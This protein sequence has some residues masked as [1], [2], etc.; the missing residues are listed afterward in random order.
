[1][2]PTASQGDLRHVALEEPCGEVRPFADAPLSDSQRVGVLLQLAAVDALLAGCVPLDRLG[3]DESGILRSRRSSGD[4]R[5]TAQER[6]ARAVGL[7]F[8]SERRIEGRGAAR[9]AVRLLQKRW[10]QSLVAIAPDRLVADVLEAAPFLWTARH[11]EAR[12][13]LVLASGREVRVAG[14]GALRDWILEGC[15]D[16]EAVLER[17]SELRRGSPPSTPRSDPAERAAE[18]FAAGRYSECEALLSGRR[19][20]SAVLGFLCAVE[21]GRLHSARR[22]L[23]VAYRHVSPGSREF[24]RLCRGAVRLYA[25]L[26]QSKKLRRWM[27][28]SL[29]QERRCGGG[30]GRVVAAQGYWDLGRLDAMARHLEACS[31]VDWN[32]GLTEREQ[33]RA[34]LHLSLGDGERAVRALGRALGAERRRLSK[35][36]AGRLWNDMISA[37]VLQGDLGGAE[38]AARHA[39]RLL[40]AGEGPA[41]QTLALHN[42]AEVRLRR[43]FGEGVEA[44]LDEVEE[45]NR[46]SHNRRASFY[47]LEMRCRWL[48]FRGAVREAAELSERA[49]AEL[50]DAEDALNQDVLRVLACR[51]RGWLDEPQRAQRHLPGAV[52]EGCLE[53]EE[54]PALYWL[55]GLPERA[56]LVCRGPAAGLWRGA[57]RGSDPTAADWQRVETLEPYRRARLILDLVL[58]GVPVD[59]GRRAWASR[60]L[61]HRGSSG[62]AQLLRRSGEGAL[63]VL[64]QHAGE[65]LEVGEEL[66]GLLD[67]VGCPGAELSFQPARRVDREVLVAGSGGS[68]SSSVEVGE[69]TWWLTAEK[70]PVAAEQLLVLLAR[71]LPS[72]PTPKLEEASGDAEILGRSPELLEVVRR[73]RLL[74]A[75]P[76]PV[77]I[78]G[79]SGTGK[80]LLARLCHRASPRRGG[81]FQAVNC[82]ALTESLALGELFGHVRGAFTGAERDRKGVFEEAQGGTVFLDEIGDLHPR[83]QGMLLRVLQESEVQR[84]GENRVRA[85]DARVVA[86]THRDLEDLVEEGSFRRDLY[87][88]LRVGRLV[89]PPLRDRGGDVEL[90]AEAFSAERGLQLSTG[91]AQKLAGCRWPGNVR[92][93]KATIDAASALASG[94]GRSILEVADLGLEETSGEDRLGYHEWVQLQ[95]RRKVSE[96]LEASEGNQAAAARALG[97][98]RQA[99]SYLVRELGVR[100][101]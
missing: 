20:D 58:C 60:H 44:L 17:L 90:L 15:G 92:E 13:A 65:P 79:E 98:S 70:L 87:F 10:R 81:P 41:A 101:P 66:R 26:G 51:C 89:V 85:I 34:L 64:A 68:L 53:A 38:R 49:I 19:R 45:E 48:I 25:N 1:M 7:L 99:M 9:R 6:L 39:F 75:E 91:A 28:R 42:L 78:Q 67:V 32:G 30:D 21:R 36:R 35:S 33:T 23:P 57:L 63:A 80:E 8:S 71:G 52:P 96:A 16:Y 24:W 29:W 37:R 69:G 86:A 46:D 83:A 59:S 31:D 72:L 22:R 84:L 4:D 43:G 50:E 55:A 100:S 12:S 5:A 11:A 3:V 14:P 93:L 54:R 94:E 95:R 88:R 82:A 40:S 73:A 76:M 27:A 61:H 56:R 2:T 97:L 74:A 62:A 77:L 47:D 18:A